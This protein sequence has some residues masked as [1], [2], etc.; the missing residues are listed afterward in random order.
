MREGNLNRGT[1]KEFGGGGR[2]G[3]FGCRIRYA[4]LRHDDMI[5]LIGKDTREEKEK[6]L[7]DSHKLA[8][9]FRLILTI[10]K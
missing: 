10:Q 8:N 4:T 3:L 5:D 6:K 2:G 1:E 7:M 9:W